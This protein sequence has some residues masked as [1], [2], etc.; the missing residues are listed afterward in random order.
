[1]TVTALVRGGLTPQSWTRLNFHLA[2]TG[3]GRGKA[4]NRSPRSKSVNAALPSGARQ[5][6]ALPPRIA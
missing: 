2:A 4:V 6:F 5:V 3:R 1:V